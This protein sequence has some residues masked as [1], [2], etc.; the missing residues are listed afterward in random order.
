MQQYNLD[1]EIERRES[2]K[3]KALESQ[4]EEIQKNLNAVEKKEFE[5]LWSFYCNNLEEIQNRTHQITQIRIEEATLEKES[6]NKIYVL[7]PIAFAIYITDYFLSIENNFLV[8]T[9][10]AV[11]I[12]FFYILITKEIQV[13]SKNIEV[14]IHSNV[15]SQIRH[16]LSLK[17]MF[18][19]KYEREYIEAYSKLYGGSEENEKQNYEKY[20]N[21]HFTYVSD[22]LIKLTKKNLEC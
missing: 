22:A 16:S 10:F 13:A 21:L 6:K 3:F 2:E 19:I 5:R 9:I 1:E 8:T 14:K 17:S 7:F 11:L 15:I 4:T 12:Y 18:N 20:K